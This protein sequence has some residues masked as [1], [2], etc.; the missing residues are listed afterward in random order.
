MVTIRKKLVPE[1][2]ARNI[3]NGKGNSK[4]KIC[5]HETDNTRATAGADN[6]A[7]LQYNGN[8]RKASWH[9]QVD[10]KEAV[11]SFEHTWKCWA[12]G[13]AKGNNEAIHIE[14]CVNSDGDYKKTVQNTA[15]LVAKIIKDEGLS[16]KDIVQHNYYSGKNCP[17]I[18]RSGKNITWNQFIALVKANLQP[19]KEVKKVE[20]QEFLND[21]GRFACKELI[22][23]G[24]KEGLFTSKHENLEKY[25]DRELISYAFAYVHRVHK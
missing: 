10:E 25:S 7:R 16:V 12:A 15:E 18:M 9:W 22:K 11:Q 14:M 5:I 8:T 23:K 2:I 21:T 20:K 4:K 6:H 17:R 3:T 19:K 24:V 13:T 1:S